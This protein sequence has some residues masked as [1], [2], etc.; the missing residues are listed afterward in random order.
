MAWRFRLP[1][2]L[3]LLAAGFLAGPFFGLLDPDALLGDMLF[4]VI[5]LSVAVILFEGGLSLKLKELSAT[6][7]VV[8]RLITTGTVVAWVL[9]SGAAY[10]ILGFDLPMAVLLGAILVVSGPTVIIPLLRHVRPSGRVASVLRWEGILI[11][12]VGAVLAVLVY[13][14]IIAGRF[15]EV[16]S[17]AVM[18]MFETIVVGGAI[19][20]A[21][22]LTVIISLKRYWIPDFL[23]NPVTIML[24]VGSFAVS[25][26]IQTESGLLAVTVMGAILANQNVV[27]IRHII[28]FKEN[29]RVL[30]IS[31]LFI[32]LAARLKLDVLMD[33]SII[34]SLAFI[35]VLVVVVR[36]AAVLVSTVFSD[37]NWR[38]RAF[39][40]CVAPRGIVAAA[41]SSVFALRMIEAG[42]PQ[43]G[44]LLPE[45]FLV[46]TATVI[47]YGLGAGWVARRL[48][49]AQAS[50]QGFLILGAQSWAVEIAKAI[51]EAGYKVVI[52]DTNLSNIF[53]SRM[54]GI[55]SYYGSGLSEA[56]FM[57]IDMD[58]IGK[59][60]ALTPNDGI[61]S[62]AVLH[63]DEIFD[64]SELYQLKPAEGDKKVEKE[65]VSK[66]LRGR[67]L[68]GPDITHG[69][70]LKR[71]FSGGIIKK[72][73]LTEEFDFEAFKARYGETAVPLFLI[74]EDGDIMV[75]TIDKPPIPKPGH[76][77]ISL[78]DPIEE[79]QVKEERPAV[80]K[81]A[82]EE[83]DTDKN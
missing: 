71:F 17:V 51:K 43:A 63:F 38:E 57:D 11:D 60:M 14:A 18:G 82:G 6:G 49:M 70:L 5:S 42:Y 50:P 75:F 79:K 64:S 10:Y 69:Y 67:Y 13:E 30:L 1:S 8:Q 33:I 34:K 27:S 78:V 15:H 37:L 47:I 16:P 7:S 66:S 39:V 2:I 4:P 62:L 72:T 53:S 80:D 58:G 74:N 29:L 81:A 12:P 65:T 26:A 32:L 21:A 52:V 40:A 45:T 77:L 3:L 48:N 61:N 68:F 35:I 9:G 24:V 76:T 36:P 31:A 46:I 55:P 73:K 56:A 19:G 28:Q 54:A 23:Q 44:G 25:N 83:E 22:A 20:T 59:L 41:I